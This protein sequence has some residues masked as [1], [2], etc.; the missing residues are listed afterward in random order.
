[1][2]DLVSGGYTIFTSTY[3]YS[4][5]EQSLL[6]HGVLGRERMAC[7]D[8]YL[9]LKS[10]KFIGNSVSTFS[11]LLLLERQRQEAWA[12]YYNGGNV[13]LSA[14]LPLYQLPWV[15]TY[16]SWSFQYDYMLKAAVRS[17]LHHGTLKP[18]CLFAGNGSAPIVGWLKVGAV[19]ADFCISS[20]HT[21]FLCGIMQ[22][23]NFASVFLWMHFPV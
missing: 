17:G 16:N 5:H 12:S 21:I 22:V 18:Y 23:T 15:F 9:A 2:M 4:D 20:S 6:G 3:L 10:D 8:Y 11:A 1:M 14:S 19:A 13:P 7:V